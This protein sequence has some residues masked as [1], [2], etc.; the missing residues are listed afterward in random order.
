MIERTALDR[1]CAGCLRP[2]AGGPCPT[3]GWDDSLYPEVQTHLPRHLL[4]NGQYYLGRALGQGG[5][6]VTYFAWDLTL[7]RAVAIKE[8]LPGGQCTRLANRTTVQ[9]YEGDRRQMYTYGL[10]RFLDEARTLARFAG[11]PCIVPVINFVEA[12]GT[13]YMVM[14]YLE[15]ITLK[16]HLA[17]QGG[18]IPYPVAVD[19]LM[20]VMDALREVHQQ[21]LLHRDIS[22]DNI[23]LTSQN[24]VY[25]IDFG[26]ARHALGEQSQSLSVILKP[27]FAPEEQYRAKGKQ[28]PWT[29]VYAL[30]ATLYRC[31]TGIQPPP[32]IDRLVQDE[33]ERPSRYCPDLPP[34]AEAA[35]MKALAVRGTERYQSVAELQQALLAGSGVRAAAAPPPPAA[36]PRQFPLPPPM[37]Q[38]PPQ[39][40]AMAQPPPLPVRPAS[41]PP[42]S[43]ISAL[44]ALVC[45]GGISMIGFVAVISMSSYGR[46]A[47]WFAELTIGFG[48]KLYW[49]F[50]PPPRHFGVG[51]MVVCAFNAIALFPVFWLILESFRDPLRGLRNATGKL[52]L[53]A[54]G[55]GAGMAILADI[56][57]RATPRTFNVL[58]QPGF[59]LWLLA[60]RLGGFS[61]SMMN[62]LRILG[63][64][65]AYSVVALPLLCRIAPRRQGVR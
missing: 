32:A 63:D 18:R 44:I 52:L 62:V 42:G 4:L 49:L 65:L 14:T 9:P 7:D 24:R 50:A 31:I 57:A 10:Q 25:L 8:Y 33:I 40:P 5:F 59:D 16:Q 15:G 35:L 3:C 60:Y 26:A 20:R 38:P 39:Q 55:I 47:G 58:V 61:P 19:I 48:E 6:G 37:P 45:S 28:G 41:R 30:G 46:W 54:L 11:H 1:R 17:M 53:A 13:A 34:P 36:E 21:G 64:F 22:P 2:S 23:F 43:L 29:D 12:N 27:G 56:L 51:L